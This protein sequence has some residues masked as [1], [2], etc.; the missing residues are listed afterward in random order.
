[1]HQSGKGYYPN[2][3]IPP[4]NGYVPPDAPLTTLWIGGIPAEGSLADV[5]AAFCKF[6][7]ILNAT[8]GGRPASSGDLSG[9]VR[10]ASFEAAERA[11]AESAMGQIVFAN[12]S[13]R[14]VKCEWSRQ[15]CFTPGIDCHICLAGLPS[16]VSDEDLVAGFSKFGQIR[17]VAQ[18]A[19]GHIGAICFRRPDDA[20]AVVS[21]SKKGSVR[22][23]G[24]RATA[25]SPPEGQPQNRS[26]Y[27]PACTSLGPRGKGATPYDMPAFK[28]GWPPQDDWQLSKGGGWTDDSH[29]VGKGMHLNPE[30]PAGNSYVPPDA[31]MTTLWV[32]GI[33]A[34]GTIADLLSA[35]CQFGGILNATLGGRP[36]RSGDLTGFVRFSSFEAAEVA[37][38]ASADGKIG[39]ASSLEGRDI[40]C[41][42]S[43]QNCFT[44]GIDCHICI[45]C[46]RSDVTNEDLVDAFGNFGDFRCSALAA[47]GRL[48]VVSFRNPAGAQVVISAAQKEHLKVKGSRVRV[49]R[50]EDGQQEDRSNY[51]AVQMGRAP[52]GKG[53]T[54]YETV[55]SKGW[56]EGWSEGWW[57]HPHD[58]HMHGKGSYPY[59]MYGSESGWP[60]EPLT[61]LW[62]GGIP[63]GSKLAD[64]VAVFCR[65]GSILNAT[66]GGKPAASG[67]LSGFVRFA[68]LE[69]AE[70]ALSSSGNIAF[71]NSSEG[72]SIH[73]QWSKS[74]C[75]VPGINCS[76]C[77]GNLN[78]DVTG[79][80]L[81]AEFA[82][83][84]S[85]Q[86]TAV[87]KE[88]GVGTICFRSASEAEAALSAVQNGSVRIRGSRP[89]SWRPAEGLQERLTT[90]WIGGIPAGST[91]SDLLASFCQ[92][93]CVLNATLAGR[94]AASG[95]LSG[96]VRF[97]LC[98]EGESALYAVTAG[99]VILP[100]NRGGRDIKSSGHVRIATSLALSAASS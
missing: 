71:A 59:E 75:F 81:A 35:F 69:Q 13:G 78:E 2:V 46:L 67:D 49:W 96:F 47:K 63:A 52:R 11:L 83:F 9:F 25:W 77:L 56:S 84:G 57:P 38:A 44:P 51:G 85:V 80:D 98:D 21:A 29:L 74:N 16:G 92:F 24:S 100:S 7:G 89:S 86:S 64:L 42:W 31:P 95:D 8:V 37:L 61:T 26:N 53:T 20:A 66:V 55:S 62:I 4:E 15:N 48:G 97:A 5:L 43:R 28:G 76:I 50:P 87:A 41:Q 23:R 22:I 14:N 54:P 91:I 27:G 39:C 58:P 79:S 17:H 18:A 32:G 65:Y 6:G 12:S 73:C 10:F 68:T 94:P 30:I 1:M 19:E 36:A 40:K 72:R 34:E 93:G 45:S 88:G 33:P 70:T 90:I 3:E 60:D 99:N 82:S